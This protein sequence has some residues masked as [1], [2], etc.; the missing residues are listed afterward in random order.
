MCLGWSTS[1]A[2]RF[3]VSLAVIDSF[4]RLAAEPAG[5]YRTDFGLA[6]VVF[7]V[8]FDRVNL[9]EEALLKAGV[10]EHLTV[11]RGFFFIHNSLDGRIARDERC[12]RDFEA[13]RRRWSCT[14]GLV[15]FFPTASTSA[16]TTATTTCC[17]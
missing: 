8:E 12:V 4:K 1:F 15:G 2:N 11:G 13:R 5:E 17:V 9:I 3:Q 7:H 14:R 10:L 6:K 16:A